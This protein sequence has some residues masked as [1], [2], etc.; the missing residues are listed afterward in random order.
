MKAIL[1]AVALLAAPLAHADGIWATA[2][3]SNNSL[4]QLSDISVADKDH[5]GCIGAMMT[6]PNPKEEPIYGCWSKPAKGKILV[7][8]FFDGGSTP[9][10]EMYTTKQFHLTPYGEGMF[11]MLLKKRAATTPSM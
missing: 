1:A 11:S 9:W 3:L 4:V 6:F 8:W 5:P 10:E 2:Q 7:T